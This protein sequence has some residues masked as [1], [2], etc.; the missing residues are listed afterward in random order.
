[1]QITV[2]WSRIIHYI[3][4]Y[5]RRAINALFIIKCNKFV[6]LY[7]LEMFPWKHFC[8]LRYLRVIEVK[9]KQKKGEQ[10]EHCHF[11]TSC[12]LVS[13]CQFIFMYPFLKPTQTSYNKVTDFL[14]EELLGDMFGCCL[15]VLKRD[16]VKNN[17]SFQ[18]SRIKNNPSSSASS[19]KFT[20]LFETCEIR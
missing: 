19:S 5:L 16:R 8:Q 15:L 13:M 1:M 6:F 2:K 9:R 7:C 3:I 14:N 4:S 11:G 17:S 10:G 18:R 12:Q 20:I